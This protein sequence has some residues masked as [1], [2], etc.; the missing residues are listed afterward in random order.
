MR[1]RA[2]LSFIAACALS[3]CAHETSAPVAEGFRGMS[4][5]EIEGDG[6]R[7]AFGVPDSD[8]VLV[9]MSCAPRS[10]AVTVNYFAAKDEP[11]RTLKLKSGPATASLRATATPSEMD[12]LVIEAT[13]PAATRV[14][15]S[16]ARS[17]ERAVALRGS[18]VALPPADRPK[19]KRFVDSCR[20]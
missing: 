19:A 1:R 10:G 20:N 9:M 17:G 14:L 11:G 8:M 6:P 3:A 4:W 7:L 18:R 13:A 5:I 15:A 16:F 12:E 2:I